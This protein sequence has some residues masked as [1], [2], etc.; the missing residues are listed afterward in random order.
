MELQ[1]F[2]PPSLWPLPAHLVCA[3]FAPL[4]LGSPPAEG[5]GHMEQRLLS[6]KSTN[7]G[8]GKCEAGLMPASCSRE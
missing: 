6:A 4:S 3:G 1:V 8:G 5:R 2:V 7:P